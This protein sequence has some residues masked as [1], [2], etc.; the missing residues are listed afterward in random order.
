MSKFQLI[1]FLKARKEIILVVLQFFIIILHFMEFEFIPKIEIMRVN[2]LFS[3]VGC[4]IIIIASI[5]MFKAIKE[6]GSNISPLPRPIANGNLVT[7]GIY[8]FLLHPMYYS[9]LLISF[10]IFIIKSYLYYL[11]LTI[12]L[13]VVIKL[14]IIL[15]EQYLKNKFKKYYLY[16][17]KVRF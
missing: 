11:C 9:L 8:R 12:I 7:T 15:E 5:V 1:K 3:F 13:G 2:S 4:L 10:G 14:K 6:L 17:D 16:L